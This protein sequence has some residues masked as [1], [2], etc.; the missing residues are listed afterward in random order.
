MEENIMDDSE[1]NRMRFYKI[2]KY[3]S[4][5]ESIMPYLDE[6]TQ[7][8]YEPSLQEGKVQEFIL[9]KIKK[10]VGITVPEHGLEIEFSLYEYCKVCGL[11]INGK[12]YA[13]IKGALQNLATH[14]YWYDNNGISFYFT[15]IVTPVIDRNKGIITVTI[16]KLVTKYLCNL[17]GNYTEYRLINILKLVSNHTKILFELFHAALFRSEQTYTIEYLRNRL[18]LQDKYTISNDFK[19]YVIDKSVKE[20]NA[21]TDLLVTYNVIRK[22]RSIVGFKFKIKKKSSLDEAIIANETTYALG[23]YPKEKYECA[24]DYYLESKKREHEIIE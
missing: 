9:S 11:Q 5:V 1:I 14:G 21:K 16:P 12:I 2:V 7:E 10:E 15:W 23:S 3:N 4:L 13:D 8:K 24:K 18:G 19:R 6:K 17:D 22:M 20:I